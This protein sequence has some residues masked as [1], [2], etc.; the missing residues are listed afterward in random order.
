MMMMM[1][2]KAQSEDKSVKALIKMAVVPISWYRLSV[3]AKP[4]PE[5]G[6]SVISLRGVTMQQHFTL[7][8][9]LVICWPTWNIYWDWVSMF[10]CVFHHRS[11]QQL[12]QRALKCNGDRT[13]VQRCRRKRVV[14]SRDHVITW[15]HDEALPWQRRKPADW[16]ITASEVRVS[17][18]TQPVVVTSTVAMETPLAGA[19]RLVVSAAC[20]PNPPRPRR[21]MSHSPWQ[22]MTPSGPPKHP[23]RRLIGC[24]FHACQLSCS[25]S[26]H[27]SNVRQRHWE[28]RSIHCRFDAFPGWTSRHRFHVYSCFSDGRCVKY[29]DQRVWMYVCLALCP[30]AYFKNHTSK[31]HKIF[32]TLRSSNNNNNLAHVT[33]TRKIRKTKNENR[34][35]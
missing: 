35:H 25:L 29:C 17:L 13:V 22:R 30:L 3:T 4:S 5:T 26:H 20:V 6:V 24:L 27:P 21:V 34:V 1:M 2:M 33:E 16:F 23:G 32:C 11:L 31:F 15:R 18:T 19:L 9:I 8:L 28:L 7:E 10:H 12:R 14:W